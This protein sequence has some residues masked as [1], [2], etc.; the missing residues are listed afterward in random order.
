[1]PATTL[2]EAINTLLAAIG[3]SPVTNTDTPQNADAII[4]KNNINRALR[5]I[6]TEKWYFNSESDYPLTPDVNGTIHIPNN[7]IN[8][9]FTGRLGEGNRFVIRGKKLYD[10]L[11]HTFKIDEQLEADVVLCLEYDEIPESAAQYVIARA[12]RRYQEEMLGD[13]SLRTWTKQ[14]EDTARGKLLDE[15]LR[16]RKVSLGVL[17][18]RDPIYRMGFRNH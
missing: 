3:S 7:I 11:N 13:P 5:D 16:M 14:D 10:R 18:K 6:Q 9:D 12:A 15:D 8:I 17:P 2:L 4:A 1:M